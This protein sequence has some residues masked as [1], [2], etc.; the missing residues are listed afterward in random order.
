MSVQFETRRYNILVLQ[1][2]SNRSR[3][4]QMNSMITEWQLERQALLVSYNDVCQTQIKE[5]KVSDQQLQTFCQLLIDY[6]LS[7]HLK[8]FEKI[9]AAQASVSSDHAALDKNVLSQILKS[10]L[11]ALEFND[12]YEN[13]NGN[14]N[15]SEAAQLSKDL[16]QI[17]QIME[18]RMEWEDKLIKNY[19]NITKSIREQSIREKSIQKPEQG[20]TQEPEMQASKTMLHQRRTHQDEHAREHELEHPHK[21]KSGD[22]LDA[23][24]EGPKTKKPRKNK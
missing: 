17:G 18:N 23:G 2:D 14:P 9:A 12:N 8:I 1:K 4:V 7:A 21:R 10:S 15:P 13:Y 3:W 6:V 22:Q 5:G 24:E 20:L 11:A 16:S 19:L